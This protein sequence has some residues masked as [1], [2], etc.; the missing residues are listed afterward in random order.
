MRLIPQ[1]ILAAALVLPLTI[2]AQP[3]PAAVARTAE[4]VSVIEAVDQ[5]ERSVVLRTP[6]GELQTL[7]LGKEVRNLPQ[8][9]PGD[10]V[11][12]RVTQSVAVQ[13]ARPGFTPEAGEAVGVAPPG[14]MPGVAYLRGARGVMVFK[15]YDRANSRVT[16]ADEQGHEQ[17]FTLRSPKMKA[18]ARG[19]KPGDKVD[20]S[21]LEAVTIDVVR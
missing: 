21:I 2:R 9:K 20:V 17:G 13:M 7:H 18:F 14:T 12:T 11:V 5:K 3:R 4:A 1:A 10:K 8:V 15:T 16:V 19:L 6:D